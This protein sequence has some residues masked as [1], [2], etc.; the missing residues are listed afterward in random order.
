MEIALT[1]INAE[2]LSSPTLYA[3]LSDVRKR[4]EKSPLYL[5]S[6]RNNLAD[7]I[8]EALT[9]GNE[10]IV[11]Q[12]RLST[13]NH[14]C[15]EAIVNYLISKFGGALRTQEL[16]IQHHQAH[17][18]IGFPLESAIIQDQLSTIKQHLKATGSLTHMIRYHKKTKTPSEASSFLQQGG[19]TQKYLTV[20][21][22]KLPLFTQSRSAAGLA[23]PGGP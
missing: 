13:T 14:S 5:T 2:T 9:K 7:K 6:M 11:Y 15:W 4:V 22:E 23:A 10:D 12:L 18:R 3:F 17:D 1:P 19:Y 21:N 16:A 20:L 8:L